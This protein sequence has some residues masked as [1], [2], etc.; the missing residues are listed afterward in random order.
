MDYTLF[1]IFS[2]NGGTQTHDLIIVRRAHGMVEPYSCLIC[3]VLSQLRALYASILSNLVHDVILNSRCG[4]TLEL[5]F[6]ITDHRIFVRPR[7]RK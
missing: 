5:S 2:T 1:F 4:G 6:E 3:R 7:L